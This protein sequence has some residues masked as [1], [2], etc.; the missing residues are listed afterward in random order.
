MAD[1]H[2]PSDGPVCAPERLPS[3]A[4]EHS[5]AAVPDYVNGYV[6]GWRDAWIAA[7]RAFVSMKP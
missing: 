4:S 3:P 2:Y 5:T 6:T 7:W 1:R